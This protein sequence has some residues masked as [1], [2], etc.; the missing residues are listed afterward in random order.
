MADNEILAAINDVGKRVVSIEK[1]LKSCCTKEDMNKMTKEIRTEI[2]NNTQRIDKLF[3]LRKADGPSL[4]KKVEKIVDQHI[5][6]KKAG[7]GILTPTAA[8]DSLRQAFLSSR[9]S[10]R[11]WPIPPGATEIGQVRSFFYTILN[12]PQDVANTIQIESV[13]RLAQPRR[14]KI[15]NEVLVRFCTAQDRDTIQSYA[16]NLAGIEGKA[17]LRID[18]PDHLRGVFRQFE[19]H[20][21]LLKQKFGSVKRSIKFDDTQQSFCMDVKLSTT[22]WHRISHKEIQSVPATKSNGGTIDDNQDNPGAASEKKRI[23]MQEE[24]PDCP[25]V[26]ES[27]D[28]RSE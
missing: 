13:Q 10:V 3:E 5:A 2:Q 11:L 27:E 9:R 14:S 26:V 24:D 8:E 21:A 12:V 25:V 23:L 28:E 19:A 15:T 20:A 16:V 4:I 1:N 7:N 17:G 18:V 6:S 22:G